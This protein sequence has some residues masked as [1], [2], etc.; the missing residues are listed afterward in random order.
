[1][2]EFNNLVVQ[3]EEYEEYL[4][5]KNNIINK[6]NM[7]FNLNSNKSKKKYK[8]TDIRQ[9]DVIMKNSEYEVYPDNDK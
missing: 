1:M 7:C 8:D 2:K 9:N 3:D 6:N 4:N 5:N